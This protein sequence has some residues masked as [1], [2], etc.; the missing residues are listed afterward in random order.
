ML[1]C[2]NLVNKTIVGNL[3]LCTICT[4]TLKCTMNNVCTTCE[5]LLS[6]W[7]LIHAWWELDRVTSNSINCWIS[8]KDNFF[9]DAIVITS[10]SAICK[11]HNT[12]FEV[13]KPKKTHYFYHI[14]A[15]CLN[16][17]FGF[18]IGIRIKLFG[19]VDSQ[20]TTHNPRLALNIM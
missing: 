4:A 2:L 13:S 17:F 9:F 14:V 5:T 19:L 8:W 1:T 3:S 20:V 18:A 6:I 15:M 10:F 16:C 7:I 12:I 11:F